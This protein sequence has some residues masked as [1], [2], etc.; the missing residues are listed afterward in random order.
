[1]QHLPGHNYSEAYRKQF[2]NDTY[3]AHFQPEPQLHNNQNHFPDLRSASR[4][5]RPRDRAQP[6]LHCLPPYENGVSHALPPSAPAE[7]D[8]LTFRLRT[9]LSFSK[10]DAFAECNSLHC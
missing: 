5:A 8:N 6:D 4:S 9:T 2:Q 1:M 7:S 10:L 3:K